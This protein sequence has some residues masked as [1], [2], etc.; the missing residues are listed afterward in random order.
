M[1]WCTC[2]HCVPSS[3]AEEN[4]CCREIDEVVAKGNDDCITTHVDFPSVCLNPAVLEAAYYAFDELGVPIE[5]EIHKKYRFVAYRLF[6]KWIWRRLGRH[7]RV[8][9]P[10][11][12]VERIRREFPS[13]SYVGFRHPPLED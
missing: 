10:A 5:G 4:V 6:T 2:D 3:N 1:R 13:A 12:T 11:C 9:L 8:V 7:N